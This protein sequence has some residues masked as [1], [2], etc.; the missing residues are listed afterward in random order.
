MEIYE[1][2]Y[3][4]QSEIWAFAHRSEIFDVQPHNFLRT[5][6]IYPSFYSYNIMMIVPNYIARW[7]DER[8]FSALRAGFK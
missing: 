5:S 8:G 7:V 6:L 4:Y 1:P 3:Q 2:K